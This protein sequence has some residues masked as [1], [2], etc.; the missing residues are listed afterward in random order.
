MWQ[1]D[2]DDD[3][4]LKT[5]TRIQVLKQLVFVKTNRN[6]EVW[7]RGHSRSFKMVPFESFGAV[8]YSPSIVT[9]ALSCISSEIKPDT[10][11]KLWFFSYPLAYWHP[12]RGSPSEYCHPVLHAQ[13]LFNTVAHW[14]AHVY[15]I[16][17]GPVVVCQSYSL[18]LIFQS[19]LPK[20]LPYKPNACM[21]SSL[22]KFPDSENICEPWQK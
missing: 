15:Q 1:D 6:L 4:Q 3:I 12:H 14:P 8:S 10:G 13:N 21:A 11:R 9:M 18:R 7:V 5:V 2:D 22:Q 17:S 20:W 16:W 19:P